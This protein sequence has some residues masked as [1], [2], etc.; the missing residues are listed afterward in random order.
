MAHTGHLPPVWPFLD[1]PVAPP[2]PRRVY[3]AAERVRAGC[4][5]APFLRDAKVQGLHGEG[6]AATGL[7][8]RALCSAG[9]HGKLEVLPT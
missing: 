3:R 2:E 8:T 5:R 9:S 7:E 6:A 4:H 1:D